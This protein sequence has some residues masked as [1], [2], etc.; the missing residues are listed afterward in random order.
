MPASAALFTSLLLRSPRGSAVRQP[1]TPPSS[2]PLDV[3]N[4]N[5]EQQAADLLRRLKQ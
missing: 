1:A 2:T 5:G 4:D 3:A